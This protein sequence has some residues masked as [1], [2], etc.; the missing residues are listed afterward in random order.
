MNAS[1]EGMYSATSPACV[2]G[3]K[4]PAARILIIDKHPIVREGLRWIIEHEDDLQ[5]CGEADTIGGARAAIKETNPQV[6]IADIS[7][8]Q[9]DGIGL[10]RDVRTDFPRLRILVLSIHD[11]AIF[12]ER[13]LSIG[14]DGYVTKQAT[15]EQILCAVRCVIDGGIYA[16]EAVASNIVQGPS[17]RKR[18]MSANPIERLSNRELQVLHSVGKGMSTRETAHALNLSVKTIEAHRQRLKAKLNLRS[19]SHLVQFAIHWLIRENAGA[20]GFAADMASKS[21]NMAND[22]R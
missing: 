8:N 20:A 12:A 11:E 4:R 22:M 5:V 2:S 17:S 18:P 21:S 10:V 6:I 9:G 1:N 19:G 7:L 3:G 13:M 14:A 16:S 15:S